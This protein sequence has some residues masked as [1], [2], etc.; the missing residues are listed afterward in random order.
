MP[1]ADKRGKLAQKSGK[2]GKGFIH[3]IKKGRGLEGGDTT[4]KRNVK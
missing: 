4:G 3:P 2:V 1:S